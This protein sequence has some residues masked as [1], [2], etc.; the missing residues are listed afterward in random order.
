MAGGRL[1]GRRKDRRRQSV[2]LSQPLAQPLTR[3]RPAVLVVLPTPPRNIAAYHA[4]KQ[5]GLGHHHP[6]AALRE[7]RLP[8][9]DRAWDRQVTSTLVADQAGRLP[10]PARRW[11]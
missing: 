2:A 4:L 8:A 10:G 11:P 6:H 3:D 7:I 1:G 9:Q 5:D